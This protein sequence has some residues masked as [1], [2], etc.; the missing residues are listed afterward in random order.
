MPTFQE[1]GPEAKDRLAKKSKGFQNRQVYR[2]ILSRVGGG[3]T[4]EVRPEDGETTRRLKVKVRRSANEMN[5]ED[6]SY[7]EPE[8]G[9]L[10]VWSEPTRQRRTRRQRN[11]EEG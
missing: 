8:D 7:G 5:L 9:A 3:K 6:I 10:L 11:G 2:D 4:F 1:V